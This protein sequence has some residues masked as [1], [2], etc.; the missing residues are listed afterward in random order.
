MANTWQTGDVITRRE[1]LSL[2]P[3]Q[4]QTPSQSEGVWLG[5]PV[6]VVEDSPSQLATYIAPGAEIGF[7]PGTWPTANGKHA[8]YGRK[9]W[10]GNG[11]LMVQKPE[12]HLAIW[13]FW[14]GPDREFTCWYLNIQTKHVRTPQG[15]DTQDLEL[16]IVV[17]PDGSHMLKDAEVLDDRVSEGRYSAE[18]VTWVREYGAELVRRL[19][20]EGPWWDR[21]WVE[22]SPRSEWLDPVLAPSWEI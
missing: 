18:L 6:Y 7:V 12:E 16:D 15:F 14:D 8:W 17:Y 21:S 11:C 13:H 5:L 1:V 20:T 19:E 10:Q 22:W 3:A 9:A 2:Q 4:I